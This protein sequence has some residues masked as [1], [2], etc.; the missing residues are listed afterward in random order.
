LTTVVWD[1]WVAMHP[2][3][4]KKLGFKRHDLLRVETDAGSVDVSL[5]PM[6]GMHPDAVVIMRGN[7]RGQGVSKVTD[8]FGVD[9]SKLIP[10]AVDA[11]SGAPVFAGQSVR[12]SATGKKHELALLQKH[13]DIAN[14][15]DIVK[16]MT[17]AKAA[18]SL[19]KKKDLDTVPDLFPKLRE[20][21]QYRWGMS[22]DLTACTGCVACTVACDLENNVPQVGRQQIL[23]G[24]EMHWIRIDRYFAGPV[25]NP[26]VTFQ[27]MLCQHCNHAPCE[28]VC[29]V[30]A[31]AHDPEGFNGQTYNRCVG[32]R[33]CA[34]ACPYK[35]RRFNWFTHKWNIVGE[36]ERDRNLRALNPDVTVRTRGV[37]EKCSF[38]IQR[39]RDAKHRAK[40]RGDTVRDG[41]L[42][43]ACQQVCPANAITFGNLKDERSLVARLRTDGRAYLALGG[44]PEHGHYGLKTLPNVSYLAQVTHKESVMNAGSHDTGH[45][46]EHK[47]D[48]GHG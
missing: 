47:E 11:I 26:E 40:E 4:A 18:E 46:S 31:T 44:D 35:I 2:A 14:R 22:I 16:K 39:V 37:M 17:V 27:P 1:S 20:S 21:E 23:R 43:T 8:G 32:T 42:K 36:S 13:N 25:D 7:G 38:C 5:Y 45:G 6:P 29:P 48:N 15:A 9:P 28:G 24:R 10:A 33:Y 34:N 41:E 3:T 30:F 19:G 12:V